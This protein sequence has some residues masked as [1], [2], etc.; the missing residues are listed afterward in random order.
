MHEGFSTEVADIILSSRRGST[1]KQY[2]PHIEAWDRACVDNS[3]NPVYPQ[4]SNVLQ[5]LYSYYQRSLSYIT[6]NSVRSAINTCVT[7]GPVIGSEQGRETIYER[8]L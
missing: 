7:V 2:R 4:V 6:I 1:V 5:F 3:W 8:Y